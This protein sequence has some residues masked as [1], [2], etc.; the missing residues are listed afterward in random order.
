M[1]PYCSPKTTDKDP[2]QARIQN[3]FSRGG[4][5]PNHGSEISISKKPKGVG[6]GGLVVINIVLLDFLFV[7][8]YS[9][10]SNSVSALWRGGGVMGPPPGKKFTKKLV[11]FRAKIHHLTPSDSL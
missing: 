10:N 6:W 11:R 8:L 9:F 1:G 7:P 4:G 5:G 3:F 2:L